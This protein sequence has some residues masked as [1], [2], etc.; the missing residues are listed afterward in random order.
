M[1]VMFRHEMESMVKPSIAIP[2]PP[3]PL[4]PAVAYMMQYSVRKCDKHS[5]CQKTT[6]TDSNIVHPAL[7]LPLPIILAPNSNNRTEKK[8]QNTS[9]SKSLCS[10]NSQNMKGTGTG[11]RT[12]RYDSSLGLLTKKFV[13]LLADAPNGILDLNVAAKALGVQKRRIYDITNVLEGIVLIEKRSKN[14][15][16]W[17]SEKTKAERAG[18]DGSPTS[19]SSW[20]QSSSI[21]RSEIAK[22]DADEKQVDEMIKTAS[23]MLRSYTEIGYSEGSSNFMSKN[24]YVSTAE[25]K[26]LPHFKDDSV[27]VIKA[28]AGTALEVPDPDAGMEGTGKRKYNI[29]LNSEK[30]RV[31]INIRP[32]KDC[33]KP[34]THS[35]NAHGFWTLSVGKKYPSFY[36]EYPDQTHYSHK[37]RVDRKRDLYPHNRRYSNYPEH[38]HRNPQEAHAA[39]ITMT[40]KPQ[41]RYMSDEYRYGG[42]TMFPSPRTSS[43]NP[44]HHNDVDYQQMPFPPPGKGQT[45][46]K[47][48]SR[49]KQSKMNTFHKSRYDLLPPPN[50]NRFHN[51]VN[52]FSPHPPSGR[53]SDTTYQPLSPKK[54]PCVSQNSEFSVKHNRVMQLYDSPPSRPNQYQLNKSANHQSRKQDSLC[55]NLFGSPPRNVFS[56]TNDLNH[57]QKEEENHAM[58]TRSFPPSKI[59]I[60]SSHTS[61]IGSL[62][63]IEHPKSYA[64][65]QQTNQNVFDSSPLPFP[66]N[67]SSQQREPFPI[68]K[69]YNVPRVIPNDH[70]PS[71][72]KINTS[73]KSKQPTSF[74]GHNL[75]NSNV[76]FMPDDFFPKTSSTENK[77]D[78]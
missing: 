20:R 70:T 2:S 32:M 50:L 23:F 69:F 49:E 36:P 38:P 77:G 63:P 17:A 55:K 60:T 76:P 43:L 39:Y 25:M 51:N 67:S 52:Q 37:N 16:A 13:Q 59:T 24:L 11:E 53:M 15:I 12:S 10:S 48:D 41:N 7:S 56:R 22:L 45:A 26:T 40:S 74:L 65:S 47:Y 19:A 61:P 1:L 73:F 62:S 57:P 9:V 21:L 35:M 29:F 78:R 33:I 28:P 66:T 68:N 42:N 4:Y 30:T 14:H 75:P 27:V 5:L 58:A 3:L 72:N 8:K 64:L 18:K 46:M 54:V 44:F 34:Q 31:P 71:P 6:C